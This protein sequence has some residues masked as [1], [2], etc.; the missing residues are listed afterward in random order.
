MFAIDI[1]S[2]ILLIAAGILSRLSL[3]PHSRR[4]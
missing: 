1:F 2:L 4:G 3:P